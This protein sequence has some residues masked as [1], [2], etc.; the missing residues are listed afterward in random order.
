M[1]IVRIILMNNT[2]PIIIILDSCKELGQQVI[3]NLESRFNFK[4]METKIFRFNNNEINTFP[5]ESV[6][7]RSVFVIASGTNHECRSTVN[8]NIM[9]IMGMLRSCRDASAKHI[10]LICAY[11]P[12]CRSD[13]KD[14]SRAPIMAKLVCDL[15]KTAGANRI[16]TFDLHAAQIQGFFDGPVDN[17]YATNMI[18]DKIEKDFFT[19]K[20]KFIVVS[21]D[22]GGIKRIQDCSNQLKTD[23]TFLVKKRNHDK[24][25]QITGHELVYKLDMRDKIAIII[26]DIGDTLGTLV[27]AA[28]ILKENGA[29]KVIVAITHGIFSG[30]AFENLKQD[31]LDLIYVSNTLPQ[32]EN[33]QKTNSKIRVVDISSLCA[34]AIICC[35]T[36]TTMPQLFN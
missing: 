28:K 17:L 30:S 19:E 9:I 35:T 5:V 25:S 6:R 1:Y 29:A 11:L 32:E 2:E 33:L 8:D 27:S 18:V 21:P 34:N 3:K 31:Y 23:Y 36:G 22:V 7:E 14:Q 16:I 4:H 13:K 10:T 12:Y 24:I 26:D 15:F 20:D